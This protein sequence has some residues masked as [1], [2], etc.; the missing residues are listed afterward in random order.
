MISNPPVSFVDNTIF[1]PENSIEKGMW[2]YG[3]LYKQ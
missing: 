3:L 2:A 1:N